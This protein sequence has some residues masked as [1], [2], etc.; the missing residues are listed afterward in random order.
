MNSHWMVPYNIGIFIRIGN[1][2]WPPMQDLVFIKG[3][4]G[5]MN[6]SFFLES[7]NIILQF[8]RM[9]K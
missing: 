3:L 6:K 7:T 1:P 5:K 8:I 2:R 9:I 4:Y